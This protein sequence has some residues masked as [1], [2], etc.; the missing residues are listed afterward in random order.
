MIKDVFERIV[1]NYKREGLPHLRLGQYFCI[2]YVKQSY[3]ELFYTTDEVKAERLIRK[4]L[5]DYQYYNSL[6]KSLHDLTK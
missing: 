5:E 3:P 6:P 2:K 4:Y 1:S